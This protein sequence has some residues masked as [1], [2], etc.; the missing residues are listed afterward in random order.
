VIYIIVSQPLA[1]DTYGPH[2]KLHPT[3]WKRMRKKEEKI[4]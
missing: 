3:V 2:V 1:A 4:F